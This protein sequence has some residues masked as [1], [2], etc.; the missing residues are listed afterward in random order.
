MQLGRTHRAPMRFPIHF[1]A[2]DRS[3]TYIGE[4]MDISSSGFSVQVKTD[5]PLPT[6]ILAGILPSEI[7]GDAILCKA[8]AVWQGGLAGGTKRA[9]YKIT[10]IA[11]QSQERLDSV[12]AD[13]E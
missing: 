10:S 12:I 5:D 9:S 6:I 1:T 2:P 11:R 7:A 3:R 4:T 8:R 13:L